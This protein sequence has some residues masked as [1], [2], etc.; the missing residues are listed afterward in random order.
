MKRWK[1]GIK[2]AAGNITDGGYQSVIAPVD[3]KLVPNRIKART[4]DAVVV[5]SSLGYTLRIVQV[6]A[7]EDDGLFQGRFDAVEV[8][9][10]ELIPFRADDQRIRSFENAVVIRGV[11]RDIA[12]HGTRRLD[13]FRIVCGDCGARFD[14][15]LDD[16]V[17]RGLANVVRIRLE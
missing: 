5:E 3:G 2:T 1:P 8:R 16:D 9:T 10:A 17:R 4:P 12:Q 14:E 7:V 13:G 15:A 11:L 6:A